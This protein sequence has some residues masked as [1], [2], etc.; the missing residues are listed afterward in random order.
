ML[1]IGEVARQTDVGVETIRYYERIGLLSEPSRLAS[2]YRQFDRSVVKRIQFIRNSKQLGFTLTEIREL[3]ALWHDPNTR[4][5]HVRQR[6]E[7]KIAEIESKV[8]ALHAMKRSLKKIV[9][10]CESNNTMDDCPIWD[11]LDP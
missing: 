7:M 11:G 5:Q 6:A 9:C 8:R 2:G 4:C 10:Q 1:K 3:L